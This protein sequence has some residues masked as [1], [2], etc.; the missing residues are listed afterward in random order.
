MESQEVKMK[1]NEDILNLIN[2]FNSG[3]KEIRNSGGIPEIAYIG[4]KNELFWLPLYECP[5]GS[6]EIVKRWLKMGGKIE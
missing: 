2:K 4:Y 1:K 3:A 5:I 6:E